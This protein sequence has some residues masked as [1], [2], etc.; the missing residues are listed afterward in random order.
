MFCAAPSCTPTRASSSLTASSQ[1]SHLLW[2]ILGGD[3]DWL[4]GALWSKH[5]SQTIKHTRTKENT[6][7]AFTGTI[8]DHGTN[9]LKSFGA[10]YD[11]W[12]KQS[13]QTRQKV[14]PVSL[15]C[16]DF[17]LVQEIVWFLQKP[18]NNRIC[19]RW[20]KVNHLTHQSFQPKILLIWHR[21]F[22]CF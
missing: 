15:L 11:L 3:T 22:L 21:L 7:I 13:C 18:K 8:S 2:S 10:S 17:R 9:V 5:Y 16:C 1:I 14:A 19:R 4:F 20:H 12:V 6:T